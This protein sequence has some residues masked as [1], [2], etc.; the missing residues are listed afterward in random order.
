MV[1]E[2]AND[3]DEWDTDPDFVN[4]ISEKDQRWGSKA[5][6]GSGRQGAVDMNVIRTEINKE[7]NKKNTFS[8]GYGG[9]FGIQKDRVDKSAFGY[10][11]Q[12]ETTKHSSMTDYKAGFGGKF[13]LNTDR[14]DKSAL[15]FDHVEKL[16]KH[17]SQ[18]DH[19]KGFGGRFGLNTDRKD[20]SAMGFDHV[21]QVAKHSSQ[22]DASKGFGGK[23]GVETGRQ[24]KAA[25]GFNEEP[26]PVGTN[27]QKAHV[28]KAD[29]KSLRGRFE[30]QAND[31]LKRKA[32]QVRQ[33]RLNKDKL[34]R[35]QELKRLAQKEQTPEPQQPVKTV[36][37]EP[38]VLKSV[39]ESPF[40]QQQ[41][42]QKQTTD[43]T[44]PQPQAGRIK[45]SPQFLQSASSSSSH[46]QQQ[47]QQQ[48]EQPN[49]PLYRNNVHEKIAEVQA[50]SPATTNGASELPK[51]VSPSQRFTPAAVNTPVA[52]QP[53][54]NSNQHQEPIQ[55]YNEPK[56]YQTSPPATAISQPPAYLRQDDEED[57]W[58]DNPEPI[59]I[60]PTVAPLATYDE[61]EEV[62]PPPQL[63][64]GYAE[65]PQSTNH[66]QSRPSYENAQ[67]NQIDM[68]EQLTANGFQ[69]PAEDYQNQVQVQQAHG[70]NE[71]MYGQHQEELNSQ[72]R[73]VALYDYQANDTDEI[74]FD[75]NDLITDI[76]QIDDG[77]W[78]GRCKGY[79]GLFPANYVQLIQWVDQ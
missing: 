13:G 65:A 31:E 45:I 27:Y 55:A 56:A 61:P 36:Q 25:Q 1:L 62:S 53:V 59:Q 20:K 24:D 23:F 22:T 28:D 3:P 71:G 50:Q 26:A 54:V 16:A 21:E 44:K 66:Y 70:N 67:K 77:W 40:K 6:Q 39:K 43:F 58:A 34:D 35:E 60:L 4:D 33:D 11:Q 75:P 9:K 17:S 10:N 68:M 78:Q 5:I 18:T 42:Q 37:P 12:Q 73:A 48:Q 8:E 47:Q 52:P 19:S 32:E 38:P 51:A 46:N 14:K 49:K 79:F 2:N 64:Q 69:R 63:H 7:D 57:E 15:G 41:Q 29:I 72:M 76:V 30:N 74:S